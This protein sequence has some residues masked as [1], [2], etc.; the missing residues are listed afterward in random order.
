MKRRQQVLKP[1]G[2]LEIVLTLKPLLCPQQGQ[3]RRDRYWQGIGGSAGVLDRSKGTGWV[4]WK[5]ERTHSRPH[6]ER[7]G[8]EGSPAEQ[9]TLARCGCSICTGALRSEHELRRNRVGPGSE[10]NK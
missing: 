1:R 4:A 8:Q 6:D 10:T 2:S 5:P 7:A 9:G 3:Y